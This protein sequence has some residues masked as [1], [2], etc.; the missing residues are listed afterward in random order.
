VE[1]HIHTG[2]VTFVTVGVYAVLFIWLMRLVAAKMLDYPA[3]EAAGKALGGVVHF[4]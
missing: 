4:G 3:T 2:F 1:E